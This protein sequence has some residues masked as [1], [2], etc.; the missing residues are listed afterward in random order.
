MSRAR[1]GLYVFCR[2]ALFANCYE[3]TPTFVQLLAKPDKLEL[4]RNEAYGNVKRAVDDKAEDSFFV[5][6]VVAL[7]KLVM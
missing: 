2:K 1:L 4:V 3:L 5:D 7:G 6:D